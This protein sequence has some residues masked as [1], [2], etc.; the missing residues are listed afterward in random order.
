MLKQ[1]LAVTAEASRPPRSLLPVQ[2][3]SFRHR[4]SPRAV[5]GL[6]RAR[7]ANPA[8]CLY[9]DRGAASRSWWGLHVPGKDLPFFSFFSA[10]SNKP[11]KWTTTPLPATHGQETESVTNAGDLGLK[12]RL[13]VAQIW[14]RPIAK[15]MPR[16]NVMFVFLMEEGD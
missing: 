14:K 1:R 6:G 9:P 7:E 2:V 8:R 4:Q 11:G 3:P 10:S 16:E 15:Q 13:S 12:Q 5:A